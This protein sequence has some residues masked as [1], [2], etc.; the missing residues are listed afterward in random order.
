MSSARRASAAVSGR[1]VPVLRFVGQRRQPARVAVFLVDQVAIQPFQPPDRSGRQ[2]V[3]QRKA[4]QHAPQAGPAA[5][6]RPRIVAAA[7]QHDAARRLG[8]QR[9]H[10]RPQRPVG[11]RHPRQRIAGQPVGA[12]GDDEH[13]RRRPPDQ[14]QNDIR[15]QQVQ[16]GIGEAG[17]HRQVAALPAANI[18]RRAGMGPALA[19][20]DRDRVDPRIGGEGVLHAVAVMG[21]EIGMDQPADAG[22]QRG[23]DGEDRVV[24]IAEAA[25]PVRPAVMGAARRMIGDPAG[26]RLLRCGDRTADRGRGAPE[27]AGEYGIFRRAEVETAARVRRDFALFVG[28]A[29]C[30][31]IGGVVEPAQGYRV[32]DRA[33]DPGVRIDPAEVPAQVHGRLDPRYRQRMIAAIGGAAIDVVAD[34]DRRAV[35]RAGRRF[36]PGHAMLRIHGPRRSG[37]PVD[38]LPDIVFNNLNEWQSP[39]RIICRPGQFAGPAPQRTPDDKPGPAT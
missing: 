7:A 5:R 10:G 3:G 2:T 34:K 8:G 31:D 26:Q 23:Q 36:D 13:L 32:G 20:V 22:V 35:G 21:V 27:H 28:P 33:L 38:G 37:R 39:P 11:E 17:R 14:R 16:V 1:A 15:H 29:K 4:V 18:V 24:E 19:L 30:L 6:D 9:R 12:A 25:R